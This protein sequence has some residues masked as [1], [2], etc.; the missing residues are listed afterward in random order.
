[1]AEADLPNPIKIGLEKLKRKG[2]KFVTINPVRT[3]YSAIADEWLP[4]KPGMDGLLAMSMVH[5]LLKH[6]KFDY[7]FLVRYT[8]ASW[9][10]VQN[11]GQKGDGLF[12][13]DENDQ[14]LIWDI[15]KEA[16]RNGIDGDIAPRCLANTWRRTA[17]ASRP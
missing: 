16:F 6:E 8:N 14:P 12:L 5:V 1:V 13:R 11:P 17:A 3:G 9:L 15:D 10:V 4:I 7:E 2:G